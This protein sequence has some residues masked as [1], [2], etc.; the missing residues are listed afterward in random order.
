LQ[1][2]KCNS[3][4]DFIVSPEE[5]TLKN[6]KSAEN[7]DVTPSKRAAMVLFKQPSDYPADSI[8]D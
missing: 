3:K 6:T 8:G 2:K 7:E 5:T 4:L 1:A